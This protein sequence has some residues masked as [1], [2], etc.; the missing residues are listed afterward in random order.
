MIVPTNTAHTGTMLIITASLGGLR[1]PRHID[2][3]SS[4]DPRER[5][6]RI[7]GD[8]FLL[9]FP[10]NLLPTVGP[11]SDLLRGEC[12][13]G[14]QGSNHAKFPETSVFFVAAKGEARPG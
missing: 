11:L 6:S 8:Y 7:R 9:R 3:L 14:C 1:R 13:F 10:L 2:R 12:Q 4:E 5:F